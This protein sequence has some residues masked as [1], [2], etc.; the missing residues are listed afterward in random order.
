M[1]KVELMII[2][3]IMRFLE[4]W[5]ND[6]NNNNKMLKV[7]LMIIIIIMRFLEVWINDDNNNNK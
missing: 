5:I 6:D 7:E 1:L 3:M 2:V 4:V